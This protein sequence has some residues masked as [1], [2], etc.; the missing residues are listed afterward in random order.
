MLGLP[1]LVLPQAEHDDGALLRVA[2]EGELVVRVRH[3][4]RDVVQ[5]VVRGDNRRRELVDLKDKLRLIESSYDVNGSM[6]MKNYYKTSSDE[7]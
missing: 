3:V 1:G 4:Q 6:K 2:Q 7:D 5:E